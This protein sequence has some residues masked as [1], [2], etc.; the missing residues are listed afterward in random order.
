MKSRRTTGGAL[1]TCVVALCMIASVTLAAQALDK[2]DPSGI[3]AAIGADVTVVDKHNRKH[4]GRLLRLTADDLTIETPKSPLTV[5]IV[6]VRRVMKRRKDG[7]WDGAVVGALI[8][9]GIELFPIEES[10]TGFCSTAIG[11]A[12]GVMFLAGIGA[13]IDK[14]H[15]HLELIYEAPAITGAG[16]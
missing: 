8:A 7:V 10:C 11:K 16:E 15:E 3:G 5:S 12:T 1:S 2:H 6:D 14:R 9:T 13:W 4:R